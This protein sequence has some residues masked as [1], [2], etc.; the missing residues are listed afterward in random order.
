M[1]QREAI[2]IVRQYI[3]N[4]N[5]GGIIIQ[6]AYL[7]GSYARNEATLESDID[8]LL[9]SDDFDTTDDIILSKPWL[10]KFR[11]DFRIEP[12]AIGTKRFETDDVSPIIELAKQEGIRIQP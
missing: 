4:L 10:P 1:V 2:N 6:F 7:F 11:N 9:V 3:K 8:V 5:A 12:I